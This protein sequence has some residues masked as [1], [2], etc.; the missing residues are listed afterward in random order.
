MHANDAT[1]GK[2]I[3]ITVGSSKIEIEMMDA[4]SPLPTAAK[5]GK[6]RKPGITRKT[7]SYGS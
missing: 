3:F 1:S 2:R 5:A 6:T 7:S 4:E